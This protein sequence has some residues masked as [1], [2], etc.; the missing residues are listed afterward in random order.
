[1]PTYELIQKRKNEI[2]RILSKHGVQQI[3]IFG[4]V[5]RQTDRPDSDVDFLVNLQAGRSLLDLGGL[6]MD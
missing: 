1:M 6:Q 3:R 4:S 2:K 5:A